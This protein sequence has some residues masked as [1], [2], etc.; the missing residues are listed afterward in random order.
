MMLRTCLMLCVIALPVVGSDLVRAMEAV[1]KGA[2]AQSKAVSTA[3]RV[4]VEAQ[5]TEFHKRFNQV[6]DAMRDF[7]DD[8]NHSP[9]QTWPAQKAERLDSAI[10]SLQKTQLWSQY[11]PDSKAHKPIR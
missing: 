10:R 6:L 1:E 4:K 9:G 7:T 3:E 11:V 8:Y 5:L 2:L